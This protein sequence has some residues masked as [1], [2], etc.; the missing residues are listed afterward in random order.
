MS[1][2]IATKR[3]KLLYVM[4]RDHVRRLST[5]RT[6]KNNQAVE[7]MVSENRQITVD[8]IAKASMCLAQ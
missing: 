2:Q 6:E 1:G 5:S 7:R 3:E 8:D 4:K